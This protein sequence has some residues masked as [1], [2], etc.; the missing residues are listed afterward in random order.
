MFESLFTPLQPLIDI[1]MDDDAA[2]ELTTSTEPAQDMESSR[3][4][5]QRN[6]GSVQAEETV[7]MLT[8]ETLAENISLEEEKPGNPGITTPAVRRMLKEHAIDIL[9]ISGTGKDGRVLKEDVQKHLSARQGSEQKKPA[10]I[11]VQQDQVVPLSPIQ[12]QMFQSMTKS[13]AIPHFLFTQI[14]NMT[15]LSGLRR[16]LTTNRAMLSRL[17]AAGST[18]GKVTALPFILKALSEAIKEMPM[19]NSSIDLERDPK[20]PHL[21]IKSSHNIGVAMDTPK[22]L[23]VPVIH[24]VQSHSIVSL[25]QELHRLGN[26]ATEGR[27]SPADMKGATIVV[28]NIGSLGGHVVAPIILDP[29]VMIIGVGRSRIVPAFE[30]DEAGQERIVKREEVVLSWSADHRVLDGATV[31]KCADKVGSHLENPEALG[32]TLV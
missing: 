23:L 11:G 26:L 12:T 3:E 20:R 4:D 31:A 8:A 22:G 7:P 10:T 13:L 21:V 32:M 28:S 25:Q 19:V 30:E 16:R 9:N 2:A 24:D 27:L 5:A 6:L 29:T 15:P 17:Q 14:I 18:T 1:E